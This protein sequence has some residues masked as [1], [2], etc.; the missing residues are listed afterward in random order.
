MW[1]FVLLPILTALFGI[2]GFW[3]VF[4]VSVVNGSV[5][6]TKGMPYI[7]DSAGYPPQSC[8]FAQTFVVIALIRF[9]QAADF[10]YKGKANVVGFWL[11][12]VSCLG[13]SITGNFQGPVIFELHFFGAFVA[14]ILGLPY[15]WIQLYLTYRV[16]PSVDRA[17]LGPLRGILCVLSSLSLLGSILSFC[18]SKA[19]LAPPVCICNIEYESEGAICE[20]IAVN[21]LF[22]MFGLFAA[23][24]RHIDSC[25]LT[26]QKTALK[27]DGCPSSVEINSH[28]V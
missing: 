12:F 22:G 13:L 28:A 27:T 8:I 7:S 24:F 15:F 6:L 23:E 26:V 19:P 21:T 10:G 18:V 25:K 20:W 1:V 9:K 11:A 3:A 5:N 2:G 4:A 14:F 16:E 17:W